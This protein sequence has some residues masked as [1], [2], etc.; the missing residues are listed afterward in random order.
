M[1]SLWASPQDALCRLRGGNNMPWSLSY[2][3]V[4]LPTPDA[5]GFSPVLQPVDIAERNANGDLL[6]Q[7]VTMKRTLSVSW[8]QLRGDQVHA[9]FALFEANRSGELVYY[10]VAKGETCAMRVYYGA[11]VKVTLRR[12]DET[13]HSQI[14]NALTVNF[15]EM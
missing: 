13:L 6:M 7:T 4:E 15:I 8:S 12:Y 3:G 9:L 5:E 10:D 2:A 14:W 1:T 11:G